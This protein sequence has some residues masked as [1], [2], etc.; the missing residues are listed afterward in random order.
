MRAIAGEEV[1]YEARL[2]YAPGHERDVRVAYV[3]D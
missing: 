2:S 3:P 1:S